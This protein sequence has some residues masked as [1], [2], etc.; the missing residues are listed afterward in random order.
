MVTNA[1]ESIDGSQ[2]AGN[3]L[4][5]EA[6]NKAFRVVKK[7]WYKSGTNWSTIIT[8]LANILAATTGI[9]LPPAFNEVM[10]GIIIL[11]MRR[12]VENSKGG[13]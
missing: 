4:G 3:T 9:D 6:I 8:A 11:F 7:P 10:A 2:I 12:A 5:A 13:T 1:P